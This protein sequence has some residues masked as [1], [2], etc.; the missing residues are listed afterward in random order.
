M[1]EEHESEDVLFEKLWER[2]M[3]AWGDDK[4]HGAFLDYA[5]RAQRLP[6]AAGR[7]RSLKDDPEKSALAKK[8][9]DGIVLAATQMLM[10]MKTPPRT[11]VPLSMTLSAFAVCLILLGWVAYLVFGRR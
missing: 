5:I 1:S 6:D 11:K 9:L 7:Y 4:V 8:K 2:V 10:S 3:E